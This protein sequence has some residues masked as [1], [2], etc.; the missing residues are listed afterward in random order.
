METEGGLIVI[1]EQLRPVIGLADEGT[2]VFRKDGGGDERA[3][4]FEALADIVGPMVSPG[5]VSMYAPV[6]R[7][8]VH[9][10][11]K[12]GRMTAFCFHVKRTHKGLFGR[13]QEIRESPS[14]YIP[15]IEA[16]LWG[17]ELK[18]RALKREEITVEE[19]EGAKPD[20][21]GDFWEWRNRA[22]KRR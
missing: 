1:P 3:Y 2:R 14:V 9:K 18:E 17:E 15:S 5:G 7:A 21:H 22:A 4:W 11:L 13:V 6:S 8:A 16:K 20:W 12:E 10:R 19:L